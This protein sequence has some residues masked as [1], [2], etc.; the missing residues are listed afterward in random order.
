MTTEHRQSPK[1]TAMSEE[2]K[3]VAALLACEA[4]RQQQE[5]VKAGPGRPLPARDVAAE[6]WAYFEGFLERIERD[7]G[8]TY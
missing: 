1:E 2:N 5:M 8:R 3:I 6:L 7:R 4:S